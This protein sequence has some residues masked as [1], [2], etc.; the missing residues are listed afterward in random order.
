VT[1]RRTRGETPSFVYPLPLD[2]TQIRTLLL[3]LYRNNRTLLLLYRNN[4]TLL[5]IYRHNRTLLLLYRNNRTLLLLYRHNRTLLLL[6]RHNRT[7]L[8]LY[9]HNRTLLLLC[10]NNRTLLLLYRHNRTL[11][12]LYRHNR[13]LLHQCNFHALL[14]PYRCTIRHHSM[15]LLYYSYNKTPTVPPTNINPLKM[16]HLYLLYT[17]PSIKPRQ[18]LPRT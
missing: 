7:L 13:T 2:C 3:L 6:Y 17:P 16:A 4:R 9:R 11:L 14:L 12:L 8:L 5:L 18:Y 15:N 10:R 1:I